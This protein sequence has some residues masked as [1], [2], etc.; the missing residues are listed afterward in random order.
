MQID[1][2]PSIE[3]FFPHNSLEHPPVAQ[4]L[5]VKH[6]PPEGGFGPVH[7]EIIIT[8]D[9]KDINKMADFMIL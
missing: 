3:P 2:I 9:I 1:G 4:S 6:S 7:A 8:I 5:S